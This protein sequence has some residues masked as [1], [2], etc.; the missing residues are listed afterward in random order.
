MDVC[1]LG[2]FQTAV[3][4]SRRC[5]LVAVVPMTCGKPS[6]G[7][8]RVLELRPSTHSKW[9]YELILGGQYFAPTACPRQGPIWCCTPTPG[10]TCSQ[11]PCLGKPSEETGR[12]LELRS[13]THSKRANVLILGGQDIGPTAC[14]RQGPTWLGTPL[15][16]ELAAI[17][18]TWGKPSEGSG[19]G[20]ELRPSTHSKWLY[21]LILGG[22]DIGPTACPRQGPI[23][24]GTP[25][26]VEH[27]AI[28]PAWGKPLERSDRGL[29]LRPSTHSKWL[30]GLIPGGQDIGPTACPRQGPSLWVNP[31]LVELAAK[32]PA[33]G[34]PL[35]RSDRG[36]EFRPSTHLKWLYGLILDG[37][38]IGPTACPRQGPIWW[39]TPP[40]V[41]LAAKSPA[42][43]KPSEGSGRGLE[44]RPSTLSKCLYGPILGGQDIGPTACPRQGPIWCGTPPLVEL[45]A[46]SPAWCKPSEGSGRGLEFRPSTHSKWLYGL[47]LGGQDIGPTACPRRGPSWWGTPPLVKLAAKSP[48]WGKPLEGSDRGLEFR[49]STH[50]KWLFGLNLDGQDIGP[51]ACPR[52]GPIWWGT[53]PLV[54]LAA[55]SPARGKP[56]EGSGRG[57][58]F[59]HRHFRNG[60]MG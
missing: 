53:P 60:Y 46:K 41:K 38:D 20:L 15:P 25:P 17:S 8:G 59:A 47:N 18:P 55:K 51:T 56:S 14:L 1:S 54:K 34:K 57:L 13:S 37:Q 28:S 12:G 22:Q 24:W 48:A 29:E 39:G 7:S 35:E 36:L 3:V 26:L 10:R 42:R 4:I 33:L 21:G 11:E 2:R 6:E 45:A 32:S 49:P 50:S 5:P 16:R 31:P 9:P 23:M 44:L 40:L 19:R 43:C 58:E 30:Y 52:Q 27:A